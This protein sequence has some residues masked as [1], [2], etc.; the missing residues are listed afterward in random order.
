MGNFEWKQY[1]HICGLLCIQ[2]VK[3]QLLGILSLS[4]ESQLSYLIR[5][6]AAA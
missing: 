5:A 6:N 1:K 2:N 4:T 3:N